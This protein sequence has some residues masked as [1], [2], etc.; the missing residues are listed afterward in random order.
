[1]LLYVR[2]DQEEILVDV[3]F[4]NGWV[5]RPCFCFKGAR[6][7]EICYSGDEVVMMVLGRAP[8]VFS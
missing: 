4:R 1:M 5:L 2:G 8:G 6:E 3:G 7:E